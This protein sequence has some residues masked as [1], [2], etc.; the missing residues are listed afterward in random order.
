MIKW[1]HRTKFK[2]MHQNKAVE[3]EHCRVGQCTSSRRKQWLKN[4]SQSKRA[5]SPNCT[6]VAATA[7]LRL[8]QGEAR[9]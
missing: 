3:V 7:R 6:D 1:T 5:I 2:A 9:R 8:I 4:Q